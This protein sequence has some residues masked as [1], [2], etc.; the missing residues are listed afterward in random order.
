MTIAPE[1]RSLSV[2]DYRRMVEAGI[3]AADERV[4]LIEGQLY[5]MAAKGTAHSAA[6]TRIDR[7]LSQR[8]AGRAL[9]RFQDP[10]QLSDFSQPE[11]DVAVVHLHPLDY[12][13]HHPTP[14]EIFLLIEV[15]DST[16]RRDRDLKVP[17]YGRSG[18]PEYWILDVQERCLYVFRE[19][20]E[21]GYGLEQRLSEQEAIAPLSFSDCL[22]QV[23]E[24]LRSP[25]AQA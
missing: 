23:S 8:L 7:V 25:A 2:Q 1:L 12:E 13:D 5:L 14:P 19:P 6:V 15:A 22:I 17:V 3:L 21:L 24:F 10:V 18:I 9:L 20:G 4:E 11:P 16:L